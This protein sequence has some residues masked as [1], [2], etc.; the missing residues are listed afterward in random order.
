MKQLNRSRERHEKLIASSDPKSPIA[1]AYRT[2]RTNIQFAAIDKELK[3][4]MVTSTGAGEGKSTTIS[5]LAIVMAQSDM[6]VLLVDADLRKPTVHHTFLVSNQRGLSTV[7]T[8][9][10]SLDDALSETRVPNLSVI[11]SGPIPPNPAELLNSVKMNSFIREA[12]GRFDA[13]LF[14]APPVLAVTDAQILAAKVDGV[15]LV[16]HAGVTPREQALKAKAQLMNVKAKLLGAVLNNK[17]M[18]DGGDYYYYYGER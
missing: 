16:I 17:H 12:T 8:G 18:S 3:T 5:N 11:P 13:V 2:L 4:L 15:I 10:D 9:R 6:D 14:D 1:E 7:V